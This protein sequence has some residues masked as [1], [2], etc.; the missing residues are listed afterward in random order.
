M[1]FNSLHIKIQ[2]F[3]F[4]VMVSLQFCK[5]ISMK[6][7]LRYNDRNHFHTKEKKET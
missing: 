2:N 1:Y 6:A 5:D 4:F 7:F 3:D